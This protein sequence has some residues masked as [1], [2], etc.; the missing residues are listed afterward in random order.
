[1]GIKKIVGENIRYYRKELG[2]TQE[3]LGVRAKLHSH[4]IS[5]LELGQENFQIETLE[6]IA[7]TLK[8]DAHLLFVKLSDKD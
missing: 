1:M 5:R 4:Y 6:K 3:K 7:K 8:I 2:W